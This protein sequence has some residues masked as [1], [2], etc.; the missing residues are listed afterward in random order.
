MN[1]YINEKFGCLL[2]STDLTTLYEEDK[3]YKISKQSSKKMKKSKS[4]EEMTKEVKPIDFFLYN[5]IMITNALSHND[6]IYSVYNESYEH[7]L[8]S[9]SS[10]VP[11]KSN[12]MTKALAISDTSKIIRSE[13]DYSSKDVTYGAFDTPVKDK[14]LISFLRA[15]QTPRLLCYNLVTSFKSLLD[16]LIY[17]K[18]NDSTHLGISPESILVAENGT[19]RLS[20]VGYL[21]VLKDLKTW[22]EKD[23][24][25][26]TN[27]CYTDNHSIPHFAPI[28]V[29]LLYYLFKH[30]LKSVSPNNVRNIIGAHMH[31]NYV[32]NKLPVAFQKDYVANCERALLDYVNVP[33]NII[34]DNVL[35]DSATWNVYSVSLIYLNIFIMMQ[36]SCDNMLKNGLFNKWFKLLLLNVHPLPKRRKSVDETYSIFT[37]MY[38]ANA[39]VEL[40]SFLTEVDSLKWQ[41]MLNGFGLIE[42]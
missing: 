22:E 11:I 7:F 1:S 5:E 36:C 4:K 21:R 28:E 24:I 17:L 12:S 14:Q 34:I 30:D 25:L 6:S 18:R 38:C 37:K 26:K 33:K 10:F 23:R 20:E 19:V 2:Y 16:T 42:Q 35:K 39:C 13:K 15:S 29:L 9:F 31:N 32:V 40:S 41:N 8:H 3:N 27:I